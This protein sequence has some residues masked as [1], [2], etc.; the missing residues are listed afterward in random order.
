MANPNCQ[1][2]EFAERAVN[3]VWESCFNDTRPFDEV[4]LQPISNVPSHIHVLFFSY[5]NRCYM[6]FVFRSLFPGTSTHA[7]SPAV[8]KTPA[9]WSGLELF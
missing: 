5:I 4:R 8:G 1:N 3:E 2:K 6:Y 7:A 9:V